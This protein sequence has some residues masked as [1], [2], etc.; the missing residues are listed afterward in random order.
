M[1][2][3]FEVGESRV[4]TSAAEMRAKQSREAGRTNVRM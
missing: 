3:M 4:E 2:L 1:R